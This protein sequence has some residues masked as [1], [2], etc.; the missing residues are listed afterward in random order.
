MKIKTISRETFLRVCKEKG[1][2]VA[3]KDHPFYSEGPSMHFL[4]PTQKQQLQKGT[5]T[6]PQRECTT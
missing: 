3:P 6:N 4:S 1:V 2:E 5:G